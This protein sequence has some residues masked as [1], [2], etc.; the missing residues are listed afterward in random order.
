MST[1]LTLIN[2]VLLYWY[3]YYAIY[4]LMELKENRLRYFENKMHQTLLSIWYRNLQI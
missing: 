2:C 1:L 3:V 4:K